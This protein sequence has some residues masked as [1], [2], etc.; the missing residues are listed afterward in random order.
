VRALRAGRDTAPAAERIVG[1]EMESNRCQ[2]GAFARAR[3]ARALRS[4]LPLRRGLRARVSAAAAA[5]EAEFA[6][7]RADRERARC[8]ASGLDQS[9]PS[10]SDSGGSG[11]S[12]GGPQPAQ[13]GAAPP[14]SP[15]GRGGMWQPFK[16]WGCS[17]A[18]HG[19]AAMDGWV[20]GTAATAVLG[21]GRVL[22]R[23]F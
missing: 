22:G 20:V 11:R 18:E 2:A 14:A 12:G 10:E 17:V 13:G 23:G 21:R 16:S 6:A 5:S 8:W 4:P 3:R 19:G 7:G 1:N 15:E 9:R